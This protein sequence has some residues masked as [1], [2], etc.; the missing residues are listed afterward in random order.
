MK[1]YISKLSKPLCLLDPYSPKNQDFM[2]SSSWV[3]CEF[4]QKKRFAHSLPHQEQ[5]KY[6]VGPLKQTSP[7]PSGPDCFGGPPVDCEVQK[8]LPSS[9]ESC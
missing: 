2:G 5:G 8:L 4:C 7:C 6:C 3:F 1:F 9:W